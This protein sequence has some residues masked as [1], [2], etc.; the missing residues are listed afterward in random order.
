MKYWFWVLLAISVFVTWMPGGERNIDD[1]IG[2]LGGHESWVSKHPVDVVGSR[3]WREADGFYDFE[4]YC[5]DLGRVLRW[6]ERFDGTLTV[7]CE[8]LPD[9][10][11]GRP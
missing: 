8:I 4:V 11:R 6:R 9:V 7:W 3:R 10:R 2:P 5:K 1:A